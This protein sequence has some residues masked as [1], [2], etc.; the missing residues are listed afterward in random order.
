MNTE[1]IGVK[2]SILN[3]YLTRILKIL[4]DSFLDPFMK[5]YYTNAKI[6]KLE[7]FSLYYDMNSIDHRNLARSKS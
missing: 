2:D 5:V 4:D 1:S 6:T 7:Y 3:I